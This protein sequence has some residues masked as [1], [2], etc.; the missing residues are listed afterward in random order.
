MGG[1][2]PEN[3]SGRTVNALQRVRGEAYKLRIVVGAANP[4]VE[5]LKAAVSK[6]NAELIPATDNMAEHMAWADIA[7]T[8]EGGTLWELLYMGVPVICWSRTAPVS[9]LLSELGSQGMVT[10]LGSNTKAA[11]IADIFQNL[12]NDSIRLNAM[13]KQ[14]HTIVDGQGA[15]R[16]ARALLRGVSG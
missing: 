15:E 1:S 3:F 10:A 16:V 4:H 13:R 2:D 7:F 14:S 8:V 6:I 5:T 11:V 12:I 9:S